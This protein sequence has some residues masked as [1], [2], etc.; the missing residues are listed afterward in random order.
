[1][2]SKRNFHIQLLYHNDKKVRKSLVNQKT[3]L[4]MEC[5][6]DLP[7]PINILYEDMLS[8]KRFLLSWE[9]KYLVRL[10][11][12]GEYKLEFFPCDVYSDWRD[13]GKVIYDEF[14]DILAE[15]SNITMRNTEWYGDKTNYHPGKNVVMVLTPIVEKLKNIDFINIDKKYHFLTLNNIGKRE[16]IELYNFFEKNPKVNKQ[17]ISSF[18]WMGKTTAGDDGLWKKNTSQQREKLYSSPTLKKYYS[19]CAIEIVVESGP[20]MITEKILKPLLMG[21]PFLLHSNDMINLYPTFNN[22]MGIDFNYFG[23]EYDK[24]KTSKPSNIEQVQKKILEISE[25]PLLELKSKYKVDFEKAK[26]NRKK[27]LKMWD[28]LQEINEEKIDKERLI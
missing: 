13:G 14:Y 6:T 5:T 2:N 7:N 28:A 1:M 27:I 4:V 17:S 25:T 15:T 21:T 20:N 22:L 11:T 18:L 16:R 3:P 24:V 8:V 9:G 12:E 10:A 23:V 19:E 26:E